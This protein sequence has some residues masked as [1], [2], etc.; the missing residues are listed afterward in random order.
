MRRTLSILLVAVMIVCIFSSNMVSAAQG[1]EKIVNVDWQSLL[2]RPYTDGVALG[3]NEDVYSLHQPGWGFDNAAIYRS[4]CNEAFGMRTEVYVD[5][6][7][8]KVG[9]ATHTPSYVY[10]E[11]SSDPGDF[12][13]KVN[14]ARDKDAFKQVSFAQTDYGCTLDMAFDGDT[15]N[16]N[17]TW[18]TWTPTPR[19]QVEWLE[20]YYS[21]P[22]GMDSI[23]LW[24]YADSNI[25]APQEVKVYYWN[26]S[27]WAAAE[28]VVVPAL[29]SGLNTITLSHV[30]ATAFRIEFTPYQDKAMTF[31]EIELME[32]VAPVAQIDHSRVAGLKWEVSFAQTSFG[33]DP[34][35]LFDG[36]TSN[37]GNNWNTWDYTIRNQDEW[38]EITLPEAVN[39]DAVN[40][41][42]WDQGEG[43]NTRAPKLALYF[44]KNG[45]WVPADNL[46]TTDLV[47][48][49]NTVTFDRVNTNRI[50][51]VFTPI[52]NNAIA[53]Y[54]LQL[55]EIDKSAVNIEENNHALDAGMSYEVSFAQTAYG[56][57]PNMLF[58]G[59]V[60]NIGN[61]WNTWDATV[62]TEDEWIEFTLQD[63]VSVDLIRLWCWDQG[64]GGNIRAPKV[65]VYY[66]EDGQWVKVNEQSI[67]QLKDGVNNIKFDRVT[68]KR[69]RMVFR[70]N[71]NNFMAFYELQL[72]EVVAPEI[73]TQVSGYKY[74]TPDNMAAVLLDA[75]NNGDCA[76][77]VRVELTPLYGGTAGENCF[78][79]SMSGFNLLT[80]GGTEFTVSNG[81]LV[82]EVTL[83]PGQKHT[84]KAATAFADAAADAQKAIA[85]LLADEDPITTQTDGFL[86]WFD[87]NVPYI[88]IPDENMKQIY[89][90]RWYTYRSQIRHLADGTYVVTEF[91]PYVG[92]SGPYNTINMP[93]G[94]HAA[95]GRWIRDTKYL[96]S[97]LTFWTDR[98]GTQNA[99]AFSTWLPTGFYNYYLV[100][101][102][103]M[104]PEHLDALKADYA[105]WESTNYHANVGLFWSNNGADGMEYSAVKPNDW[106]VNGYRPTVNAYRYSDA[107][108]I[109]DLCELTGDTEG[110]QKFREKAAN[111]QAS[112][113]EKLFD[114]EESFYKWIVMGELELTDPME[115]IGYV[116]WMFGLATDDEAHATAWQ[117]LISEDYFAAD[118]G[119]RTVEKSFARKTPAGEYGSG[120]CRWDGPSWPFATS[121][122]LNA[123]ANLL[124]DYQNHGGVDAEDYA[125]LLR[126]Y[127]NSHYKDGYPWIAED[128][129]A[130]TG[131]W[132][133][134]IDRSVMYN[135]SEYVNLMIT[136][137]LGLRPELSEDIVVN[138][139][140][141][142]NWDYFCLEKVR[143]NGKNVTVLFDRDGS[144]YG[145]GAGFQIIVDGE[146]RHTSE[147]VQA[148]RIT[149][150][151]DNPKT[152]NGAAI[153]KLMLPIGLGAVGVAAAAAAVFGLDRKRKN[154]T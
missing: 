135:H 70:A 94:S 134:D 11:G 32:T 16:A 20:V 30:T 79:G 25:F 35:M 131:K 55:L 147:T 24:L 36:D 87:E 47:N 113:E 53:F 77:T 97:A 89:Y 100:T 119:P 145:K 99:R 128:L 57:H 60:S 154:N 117:Y 91:L 129:D 105:G 86:S 106:G 101:R 61:N 93:L 102:D 23:N 52:P 46:S 49:L 8:I 13:S 71:E 42:C 125:A 33:A 149:E 98:E 51:M 85:G 136:G 10:M 148:V 67:T 120:T 121:Q 104:V 118:F 150:Q 123:M 80:K 6:K 56:A 146:V 108:A 82:A 27:A 5:G 92:W 112:V 90:Y 74:I 54:E 84:F 68:A 15:T 58:D 127:A 124:N 50:R 48:G 76:S 19:N 18:N 44:E 122:T 132:I 95:E 12:M 62:R 142:A 151:I 14:H 37:I 111:I 107:M 4:G 138:P 22:K 59:D 143:Y 2:Q 64:P 21:E 29:K 3:Y 144:H 40:L 140:V 38:L 17:Q 34:S 39:L 78:T 7:P 1:A 45:A 66:E 81:K 152:G 96:N 139:L 110:A 9:N 126:T 141:P 115:L 63:A 41:W 153:S 31:I 69:F 137:L 75:V 26:G 116:P 103:S 83:K 65:S 133:A 28:K 88:D 109:A 130:D 73:A 72:V 43:G 114:T